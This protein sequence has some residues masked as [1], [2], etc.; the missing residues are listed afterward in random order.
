MIKTVKLLILCGALTICSCGKSKEPVFTDTIA[1][2][3]RAINQEYDPQKLTPNYY[4]TYIG[5]DISYLG[6]PSGHMWDD[7]AYVISRIYTDKEETKLVKASQLKN[8]DGSFHGLFA[9]GKYYYSDTMQLENCVNHLTEYDGEYTNCLGDKM[10]IENGKIRGTYSEYSFSTTEIIALPPGY[11][12]FET[13]TI[14]I[15]G[16]DYDANDLS[17]GEASGF[18]PCNI[19]VYQNEK[20]QWKAKQDLT[21]FG[22]C[23]SMLDICLS[24]YFEDWDKPLETFYYMRNNDF[25]IDYDL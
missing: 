8:Y 24:D 20:H 23:F 17:E 12:D 11:Y 18:N 2:N 22:F 16:Q 4:Q 21:K 7:S 10:I 14:T 1:T 3:F 6:F 19:R 25:S 15:D 5:D 9:V 13:V